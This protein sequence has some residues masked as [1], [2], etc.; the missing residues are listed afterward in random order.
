MPEKY[1]INSPPYALVKY[2]KL[3]HII[4]ASL[5]SLNTVTKL[6]T[7]FRQVSQTLLT[8]LPLS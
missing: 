2:I 3:K 8:S 5:A 6:E 4:Y 1:Y 7:V